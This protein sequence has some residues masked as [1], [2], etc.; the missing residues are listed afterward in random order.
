MDVG[1]GKNVSKDPCDEAK[2]ECNVIQCPYGKE[3]FVDDQ[4]CGRC[5]CV[6]PCRNIHCLEG[7][8]CSITLAANDNDGTEYRAICRSSK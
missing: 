8:R 1:G 4:D 7:S 5:R 2:D 3:A 6:D